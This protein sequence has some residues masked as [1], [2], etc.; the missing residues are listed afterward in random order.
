MDNPVHTQ[1]RDQPVFFG[2]VSKVEWRIILTKEFTRM[3]IKRN[4]TNRLATFGCCLAGCVYHLLVTKMNIIEIT[5]SG[6]HVATRQRCVADA[7]A[8]DFAGM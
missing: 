4:H 7:P 3:R 8:Q 6:H 5:D 2:P 1:R